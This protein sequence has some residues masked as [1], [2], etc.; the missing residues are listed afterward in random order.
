MGAGGRWVG[1]FARAQYLFAE[2]EYRGWDA[3]D[4]HANQYNQSVFDECVRP[5]VAAGQARIIT[6]PFAVSGSLTIETAPGHTAG[7]AL[8]RLESPGQ[9]AYFTGDAFHHPVQRERPELCLP[10]CDD[11]AQAV[12]TPPS[13]L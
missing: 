1:T 6:L 10:R 7:H 2:E 4:S 3:A 9:R 11:P 8:L 12:A 13:L 5:V